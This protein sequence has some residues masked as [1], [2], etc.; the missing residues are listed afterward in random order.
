MQSCPELQ[1]QLLSEAESAINLTLAGGFGV[2]SKER[3][4]G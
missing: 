2:K 3:R 4:V 1:P